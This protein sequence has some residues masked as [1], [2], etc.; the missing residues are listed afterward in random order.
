MVKEDG[1]EAYSST[2]SRVESKDER[3]KEGKQEGYERK[4]GRIRQDTGKEGRKDKEGRKEGY[5][6]KEVRKD[7]EGRKEGRKDKE[8]R[9]EG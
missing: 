2:T 8:G 5:E 1:E 6:R 4:E 7:K 9:K 3:G